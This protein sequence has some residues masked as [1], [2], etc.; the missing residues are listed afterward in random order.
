MTVQELIN[1]LIHLCEGKDPNTIEI[2]KV[3]PAEPGNMW[4]DDWDDFRID[5]AGGNYYP[6][7]VLIK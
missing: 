4:G 3:I 2:K 5:T 1:E 6:L 7:V